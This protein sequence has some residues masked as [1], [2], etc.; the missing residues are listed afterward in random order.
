M[1]ADLDSPAITGTAVIGYRTKALGMLL[2]KMRVLMTGFRGERLDED[3]ADAMTKGIDA[4]AIEVGSIRDLAMVELQAGA[5]ALEA[6]HGVLK[7]LGAEGR[8]KRREPEPATFEGCYV[9]E[10]ERPVYLKDM[11]RPV[12]NVVI[13]ANVRRSRPEGGAR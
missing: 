8:L 2:Q 12:S 1:A 6:A 4:V 5:E 3:V 11:A 7:A 9:P 13:L 10:P